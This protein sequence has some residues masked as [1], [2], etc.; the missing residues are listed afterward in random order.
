MNVHQILSGASRHDAVT[1]EASEF[2]GL[3]A[4]WGWGGFDYAARIGAGASNILPIARL[5]PQPDDVL[6]LHHSASMPHVERLLGLPNPKLLVYHNITPADYL[7]EHAPLVAGHCALGRAQLPD[8][9]RAV[10]LAAAHSEFNARE[11]TA[12]GAVRTTVIPV[13]VD[14]SRL[15]PFDGGIDSR[16]GRSDG[17]GRV[18]GGAPSILFVG[19]LSPHKGQAE[20]IKVFSLYRQHR[21]PEAQL[22]LVGA[23]LA[24]GYTDSLHR[25]AEKHAPGAITIE[26]GLS[27]HTLGD[28]YRS[29]SAFVCLSEHEGFCVPLLE[30][31]RAQVPVIS[32]PSGA[33]P[34]VAGD[35]AL[36]VEDRD[37]AVLA[38]LINLVVTDGGL[39]AELA[40]RGLSRLAAF[41]RA[42]METKLRETVEATVSAAAGR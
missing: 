42:P 8:L 9:I 6:V 4:R 30:A 2:R 34:E 33:I 25:L 31:F 41:S 11:L 20:L 36:L 40:R 15:G 23:P 14:L 27:A 21:A 38:E 5:E 39:R 10:N 13:F 19:R 37:P 32:H 29:A 12:L 28:R 22:V 16:L 35:A 26:S 7:W 3:F 18:P 1:H 17:A 24:A